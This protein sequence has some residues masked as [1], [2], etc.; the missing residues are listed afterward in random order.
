LG[1]RSK[2]IKIGLLIKYILKHVT[3]SSSRKNYLE[4]RGFLR[5]VPLGEG[6][7][8]DLPWTLSLRSRVTEGQGWRQGDASPTPFLWTLSP[9][10]ALQ[11]PGWQGDP[12]LRGDDKMVAGMTSSGNRSIMKHGNFGPLRAVFLFQNETK[13]PFF[14]SY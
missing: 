4:E 1:R 2:A 5:G 13:W 8:E 12:R 6:V 14:A 11:G 7:T 3:E 10:A 9:I